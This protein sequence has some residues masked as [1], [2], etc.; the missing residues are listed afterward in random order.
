MKKGEKK[1]SN[2]NINLYEDGN[3]LI[4]VFENANT[5]IKSLITGMIGNVEIRQT[6][7]VAPVK[8]EILPMPNPEMKKQE[9]IEEIDE[10]RIIREKGF[11][12]LCDLYDYYTKNCKKLPIDRKEQLY[13]FLVNQSNFI[14][15]LNP[16]EMTDTQIAE[17]LLIGH[18]RNFFK[19]IPAIL[20]QSGY[21]S[22]E[23]YVAS[24]R[25]NL[26]DMFLACVN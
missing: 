6:P 13:K 22:I 15:N 20:Q 10:N 9:E 2:V 8:P 4:V 1:M 19:K 17:Y 12:G 16:D 21:I 11:E 18:R 5:S 3:R 7:N 14:K 23:D 26:I 25:Q 24:G